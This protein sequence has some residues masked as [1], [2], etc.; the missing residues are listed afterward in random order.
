MPVTYG[1]IEKKNLPILLYT[2]NGCHIS[3]KSFIESAI[4]YQDETIRTELTGILQGHPHLIPNY[5]QDIINLNSFI[6]ARPVQFVLI[7]IPADNLKDDHFILQ[8]KFPHVYF[9]YYYPTFNVDNFHYNNFG[10]F[11]NLIV[12]DKRVEHLSEILIQLKHNFWKKIPL[13]EFGIIFNRLSPR[14]KRVMNYIETHDLKYCNAVKIAQ[15]LEISP[16]YFSQE[17]KREFTVS[18]RKFMQ[19]LIDHYEFIILNKLDV[20]AKSASQILGYSELSSFSRSFKKRK[21]YP[22]SKGTKTE[23]ISSR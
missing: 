19:K 4:L 7:C 20:S 2:L 23:S 14:M 10:H 6:I 3:M 1:T 9:I 15:F 22:P 16:G 5:F 18:F 13:R 12:G 21:G 11:T 8:E 17:F